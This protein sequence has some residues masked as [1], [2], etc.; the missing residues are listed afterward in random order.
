MLYFQYKEN[1]ERFLIK[2]GSKMNTIEKNEILAQTP[3]QTLAD[4]ARLDALIA[5]GTYSDKWPKSHNAY[6]VSSW[7]FRVS[8]VVFYYTIK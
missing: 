3:E 6:G 7:L 1:Q 4:Y 8:M 5:K 2:K